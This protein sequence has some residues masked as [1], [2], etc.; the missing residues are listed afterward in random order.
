MD[1]DRQRGHDIS[2]SS[3]G[4][5]GCYFARALSSDRSAV[6]EY[7]G[8]FSDPKRVRELLSESKKSELKKL[9]KRLVGLEKD[10]QKNLEY[11]KKGLLNEEEFGAANV[12]RRDE[13]AE[14]EIR[15]A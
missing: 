6:L 7:L 8:Q 10:F 13:R 1:S 14:T 2:N 11:L 5:R 12:F 9:E 15:L 4:F 3:V